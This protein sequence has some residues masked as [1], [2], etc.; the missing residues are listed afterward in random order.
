MECGA[1][2][3]ESDGGAKKPGERQDRTEAE[4]QEEEG[5]YLPE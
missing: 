1:G 2:I 5:I 3:L 4:A